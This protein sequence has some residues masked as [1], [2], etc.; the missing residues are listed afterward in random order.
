MAVSVKVYRLKIY[1]REFCCEG[2]FVYVAIDEK[3]NQSIPALKIPTEVDS[4]N[5][6]IGRLIS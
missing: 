6:E 5:W 4:K 1:G 3:G 2:Y